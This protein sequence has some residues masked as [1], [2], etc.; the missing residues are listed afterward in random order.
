[1][2]NKGC[3]VIKGI[4]LTISNCRS[5]ETLKPRSRVTVLHTEHVKEPGGALISFVLYPCSIPRNN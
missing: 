3:Y 4:N 5:D 2:G 1:M